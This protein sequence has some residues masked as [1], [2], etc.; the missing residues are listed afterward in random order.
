MMRKCTSHTIALILLFLIAGP[1]AAAAPP[2]Q[3]I[4]PLRVVTKPL[5]PFVIPGDSPQ[6]PR[7][8]SVDLWRQI[9]ADMG[10][11]YEWV[12]VDTV[13]EMLNAV[14]IGD[15]DVAIAGISITREREARVDFSHPYFGSGLQ[16]LVPIRPHAALQ[17]SLT[18]AGR[19]LLP[20]LAIG[21]L[22]V[23]VMAHLIWLSER[24]SNA[25]FPVRYLPGVW[26]GLWY[27]V[28]VLSAGVYGEGGQRPVRPWR[29]LAAMLWL[30]LGILLVAQLTATLTTTQTVHTLGGLVNGPDD[31]PG[32][33]V[34]A[35]AG[36]T[37]ERWLQAQHLPYR[38]VVLVQEAYVLLDSGQ[39]DALVYDSPVLQYYS[40]T[41]GRGKVRVV[42]PLLTDEGYGI[43]TM[44]GSP[45]RKEI[46][47]AILKL[48]ADGTQDDIRDRW[49]KE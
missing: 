44:L 7:G 37:G 33:R 29:R 24:R 20:I 11:G 45:L 12:W 27:A 23:L 17:Q 39:A 46:N 25:A 22:T 19:A 32:K 34:L 2:V 13:D 3:G 9:A 30:A 1:L 5:D 15:A 10:R 8:F 42:G 35:V 26:E 21:L 14:Q 43:A 36:T 47:A 41:T 40:A 48:Q 6:N 28:G 4:P 49:F 38:T 31:L 18:T 16:I